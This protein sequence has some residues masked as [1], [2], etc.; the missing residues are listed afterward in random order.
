M[1][2]TRNEEMKH[3]V[4]IESD[5]LISLYNLTSLPMTLLIDREGRI[6][7]SQTGVVDK[8]DWEGKI[9]SLLK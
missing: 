9:E 2:H 6:A 7:V 8:D 5:S 1:S 4:V 3:P